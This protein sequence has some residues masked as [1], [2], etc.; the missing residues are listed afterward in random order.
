MSGTDDAG[1]PRVAVLAVTR[2][3]ERLLLAQ[4]RNPPDALKWGFPGGRVEP[5]ETLIDAAQRE[6]L[7]ETGVRGVAR[8]VLTA[9]DSIHHDAGGGLQFH[10][11]LVVVLFDWRAGAGA[12]ADDVAAIDWLTLD[13]LLGG[14]RAMSRDVVAVARLALA[15]APDG[16]PGA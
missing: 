11:V 13:D 6:L 15:A 9:L 8:G 2:R 7:E 14:D 16:D 10:Y 4:R 1:R 5:G 12:P 3:G